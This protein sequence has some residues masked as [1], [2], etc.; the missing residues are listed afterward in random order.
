MKSFNKTPF[1]NKLTLHRLLCPLNNRRVAGANERFACLWLMDG[2]PLPRSGFI[3]PSQQTMNFE[4]PHDVICACA[5]RDEPPSRRRPSRA[6]LAYGSWLM[7]HGWLASPAKR[8]HT[9][10]PQA[11]VGI[12]LRLDFII[13]QSI[14]LAIVGDCGEVIDENLCNPCNLWFDIISCLFVCIRG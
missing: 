6:S 13:R 14:L 4:F 10:E 12:P 7:A 5:K 3:P 11:A 2:S 1:V 8:I 9:A